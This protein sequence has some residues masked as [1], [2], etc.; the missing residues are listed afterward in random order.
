MKTKLV[1]RQWK[2]FKKIMSLLNVL[3]VPME[4]II[5]LKLF[6][7]YYILTFSGNKLIF[8]RENFLHFIPDNL[9]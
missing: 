5:T 9:R 2:D 4:I 8:K 1:W 7:K 6:Q 3:D